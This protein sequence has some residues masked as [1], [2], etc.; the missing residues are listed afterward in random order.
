MTHKLLHENR[1]LMMKCENFSV[2]RFLFDSHE[3]FEY[4][5]VGALW[6][7]YRDICEM[8]LYNFELPLVIVEKSS[9]LKIQIFHCKNR[10]HKSSGAELANE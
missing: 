7:R 3:E 8:K 6:R 10:E 1:K 2:V 9:K 4:P 5:L